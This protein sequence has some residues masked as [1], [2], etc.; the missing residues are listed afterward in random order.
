MFNLQ[1]ERKESDEETAKSSRS[2]WT[3]MYKDAYLS[4]GTVPVERYKHVG[5]AE[6]EIWKERGVVNIFWSV[7]FR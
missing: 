7:C 5:M 6:S 4:M 3:H 2:K 1:G